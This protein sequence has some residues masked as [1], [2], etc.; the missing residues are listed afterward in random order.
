MRNPFKNLK[1]KTIQELQQDVNQILFNIGDRTAQ[2]HVLTTKIKELDKELN[3]MYQDLDNV[4]KKAQETQRK[5][6][7]EVVTKVKEGV[8]DEASNNPTK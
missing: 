4:A 8:A 7:A 1:G 6:K 3:S 2:K 5:A